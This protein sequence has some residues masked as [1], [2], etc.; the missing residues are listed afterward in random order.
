[1]VDIMCEPSNEDVEV[2]FFGIEILQPER[3]GQT[4]VVELH[5]HTLTIISEK[6]CEKL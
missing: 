4:L 6:A 5:S 1:M 3:L 2:L